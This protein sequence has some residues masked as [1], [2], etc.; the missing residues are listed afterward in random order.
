MDPE[1]AI[2]ALVADFRA[3]W[4]D[5]DAA[6]LAAVFAEDAEFTSWRGDRVGGR[7]GVRTHHAAVFAG[8]LRGTTL[9]VDGV[10]IRFVRPDVAA[11]DVWWAIS[12]TRDESGG[13]TPPRRGVQAWIVDRDVH[14]RWL[15]RVFH[16]IELPRDAPGPAQ[17]P[18]AT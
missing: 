5:Q 17:D 11:V 15:I 13:L 14:G 4:N 18:P 8:I 3:A 16:N 12:G 1:A 10:L 2:R 6:K 7:V 9:N